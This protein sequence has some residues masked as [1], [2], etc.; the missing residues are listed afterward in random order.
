MSGAPAEVAVQES[1]EPKTKEEK[2]GNNSMEQSGTLWN[3]EAIASHRRN[4][5]TKARASACEKEDASGFI[6][7]FR[8]NPTAGKKERKWESG[9]VDWVSK[10]SKSKS[11]SV[12]EPDE[13][14][15]HNSAVLHFGRHILCEEAHRGLLKLW[16]EETSGGVG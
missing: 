2:K 6:F 14:R 12:A 10:W 9:I 8:R 3:N 16:L 11:Q 7:W 4:N 15:C 13:K 5:A 1:H